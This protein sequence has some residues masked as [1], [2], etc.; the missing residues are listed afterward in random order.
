MHILGNSIFAKDSAGNLLSRIGTMFF[1]TPGL[2]TQKGVHAMQRMAWI[3]YVNSCLAA[4]GKPPLTP[5][6]EED[7]IAQSVDLIFTEDAILI[8]PDPDRMDL[9]LRADET[10]RQFAS[11]RQIRFL[12]THSIKVRSA[13]C[14]R[15]ENWR[16]ARHPISDDDMTA[17]IERSHVSIDC[18]PVYYYNRAT[19]TRFLTAGGYSEVLKLSNADYRRQVKEIVRGLNQRNSCTARWRR[20]RPSGARASRRSCATNRPPTMNGAMRCARPSR[21]RPTTPPPTNASL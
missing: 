17:L 10:L 6:E 18:L 4:E 8:R 5:E 11:K 12:N 7:E 1:R 20:S 13:L 2:V 16:M 9:A 19:G 3:D 15:G 14:E 21:A